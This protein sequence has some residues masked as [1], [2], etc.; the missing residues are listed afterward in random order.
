MSKSKNSPRYNIVT[1]DAKRRYLSDSQEDYANN[2]EMNNTN[3][4][5]MKRSDTT[6]N[7]TIDKKREESK[8]K[9]RKSVSFVGVG[10][11]RSPT[12]GQCCNPSQRLHRTTSILKRSPTNRRER[13]DEPMDIDDDVVTTSNTSTNTPTSTSIKPSRALSF[14]ESLVSR[15]DLQELALLTGGNRKRRQKDNGTGRGHDAVTLSS[16]G[17]GK[18]NQVSPYYNYAVAGPS[19]GYATSPPSGGGVNY[20]TIRGRDEEADFMDYE[21]NVNNSSTAD[22]LTFRGQTDIP[23]GL[24]STFNNHSMVNGVVKQLGEYEVKVALQTELK[25]IMR[26]VNFGRELRFT[27]KVCGNDIAVIYAY[28]YIYI[29]IYSIY[30][31]YIYIDNLLVIHNS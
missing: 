25:N 8:K 15:N 6:L 20:D 11:H 29:Y 14:S 19:S 30:I 10:G 7:K 16:D 27:R 24:I 23:T 12:S 18:S 26:L 28:I 3:T 21:Y 9:A 5:D 1:R 31:I 13:V 4:R 17:R 2:E 22:S